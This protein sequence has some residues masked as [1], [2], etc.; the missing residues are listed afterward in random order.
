MA[1]LVRHCRGTGIVVEARR[2]RHG[3]EF[4]VVGIPAMP[5][6]TIWLRTLLTVHEPPEPAFHRW[7]QRPEPRSRRSIHHSRCAGRARPLNN[8]LN[9]KQKGRRVGVRRVLRHRPIGNLGKGFRP[10]DLLTRDP[11]ILPHGAE[12]M[13]DDVAREGSI[14]PADEQLMEALIPKEATREERARGHGREQWPRRRPHD[15][16]LGPLALDLHLGA[17]VKVTNTAQH[18]AH[19]SLCEGDFVIRSA[20]FVPQPKGALKARAERFRGALQQL[21]QPLATAFLRRLRGR[22]GTASGSSA[23]EECEVGLEV[24]FDDELH[25]EQRPAIGCSR[26]ARRLQKRRLRRVAALK[27][28]V[29]RSQQSILESHDGRPG[30]CDPGL[31]LA[32]ENST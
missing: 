29:Q 8:S 16:V 9:G 6:E 27:V 14:P 17:P 10:A 2:Q 28:L 13:G 26:C 11:A 30:R 21:S 5:P 15:S 1:L 4:A 25:H 3:V 12:P 24:A 18:G 23:T 32:I 7:E 20:T 19:R 31:D 22:I